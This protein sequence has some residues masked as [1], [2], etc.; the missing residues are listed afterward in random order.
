LFS[1]HSILLLK[2]GSLLNSPE[3]MMTGMTLAVAVAASMRRS[4]NPMGQTHQQLPTA[5]GFAVNR[6]GRAT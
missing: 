1:F 5:S 4:R 6:M 3:F 2:Q